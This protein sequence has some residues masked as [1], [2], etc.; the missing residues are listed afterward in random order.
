MPKLKGGIMKG[1]VFYI[2]AGL[3]ILLM[4][5][6]LAKTEL[7]TRVVCDELIVINKEDEHILLQN[8]TIACSKLVVFGSKVDFV[9]AN[10]KMMIVDNQSESKKTLLTLGYVTIVEGEDT[11]ALMMSPEGFGNNGNEIII[12]FGDDSVVIGMKTKSGK[13]MD[14]FP[15][16]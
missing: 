11:L 10:N 1:K 13:T 6:V 7:F 8:G 14:L 2:V 15:K 3:I 9:I 5:S 4:G 16:P 12:T